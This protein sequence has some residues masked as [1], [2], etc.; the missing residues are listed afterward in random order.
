M[1]L[2]SCGYG[3][4]LRYIAA[5]EKGY[6]KRVEAQDIFHNTSIK[7][8]HNDAIYSV[9]KSKNHLGSLLAR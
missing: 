8:H 4:F 7:I 3:F 6:I 2:Q 1:A 9:V 5:Q